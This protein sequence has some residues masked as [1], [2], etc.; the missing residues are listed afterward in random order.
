[1]R[2]L[3]VDPSRTVTV[4]LA[5][6][7]VKFGCE[8]CAAGSGQEALSVLERQAVD[9][10]CFTYELPDMNG[11]DFFVAAKA[12]RLVHTQPCLLLTSRQCTDITT[13]ALKAGVTECFS[14]HRPEELERFVEL[15]VESNRR[16]VNGRVL[17]VE[18][19]SS[20]A[21]FCREVLE[22]MG[23]QVEHCQDAEKAIMLWG[24]QNYDLVLTDYV[25]SGSLSGLS[26]IRAV[27]ESSGKKALTPILAISS[28]NDTAR[29]VEILRNGANDFVSKPMVA[30]EL[31]A[32]VF[33]LLSTQKLMRQLEMQ[34]ETMKGI[35]MHDPLTS[36]CN[37]GYLEEMIP[38]LIGDAHDRGEPLSLIVVDLDGFKQINDSGGHKAGDLALQQAAK[39]MQGCSRSDDLVARIGGD[40]FVVVLPR[41]N[42]TDAITRGRG[43]RTRI[44]ALN[45]GG[46]AVTASIGVAALL[47]GE[48]YDTLFR[49]ADNAMYRAKSEGRN[50]VVAA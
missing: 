45:P 36:L 39:S 25:L 1:M 29:K 30:E 32:R 46:M 12:R 42:L 41:L 38:G 44:A 21:L 26:I 5:T 31:E 23:L 16:R 14:K 10:L 47:P 7:F 17:L 35:A 34:H 20:S 4:T 3:I 18:D 19:S 50:R 2:V 9:L 8:H 40:E 6:L 48:D 11:I 13:M 24:A 28:F 15:F 27:R 22:R 33:N 43:I 37:R 49:R